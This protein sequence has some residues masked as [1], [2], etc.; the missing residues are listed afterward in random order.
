MLRLAMMFFRRVAASASSR[1]LAV[2]GE[3]MPPQ[4][5]PADAVHGETSGPSPSC[6]RHSTIFLSAGGGPTVTLGA[7]TVSRTH[8]HRTAEPRRERAVPSASLSDAALETVAAAASPELLTSHAVRSGPATSH[9]AGLDGEAALVGRA[10]PKPSHRDDALQSRESGAGT[11]GYSRDAGEGTRTGNG[12]DHD[13]DSRLGWRARASMD[14][15][16]QDTREASALD[17]SPAKTEHTD[18]GNDSSGLRVGPFLVGLPPGLVVELWLQGDT[19]QDVTV[20][21]SALASPAPDPFARA[22]SCSV[23]VHEL[24]Y[25]RARRHLRRLA[26]LLGLL[27][28]TAGVEAA[29]RAARSLDPSDTARLRKLV[30]RSDGLFS[31][32][33]GSGQLPPAL[34]HACGGP[35]ARAAGFRRDLRLSCPVYQRLG[36]EC[37][38][39]ESGDVRARVSQYLEE[40]HQALRIGRRAER[41]GVRL[42]PVPRIEAPDGPLGASMP[43]PP[44]ATMLCHELV[45][46]EWDEFVCAVASLA[47]TTR[48]MQRPTALR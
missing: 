4:Q 24:E 12:A 39:H 40:A 8:H 27:G 16:R 7:L 20:V 36:F 45:G 48:R 44:D 47:L 25:D 11:A 9:S 23:L 42:G 18:R 32:P 1:L 3:A 22:L 2:K 26:D 15:A 46:L 21:E 35:T 6:A 19:V 37:V 33:G 38:V 13:C 14:P 10:C 5:E 34:A 29:R 30:H 41:D 17:P 31:L 28:L 43:P